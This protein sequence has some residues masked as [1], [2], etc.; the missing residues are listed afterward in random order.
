MAGGA[1]YF[2]TVGGMGTKPD[3]EFKHTSVKSF[4][5]AERHTKCLHGNWTRSNKSAADNTLRQMTIL[6]IE[7][8]EKAITESQKA[9]GPWR[10]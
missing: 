1:K 3:K 6:E 8:R 2:F 10:S 5:K 9:T 4:V 7:T